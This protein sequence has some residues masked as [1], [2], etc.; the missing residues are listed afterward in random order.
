MKQEKTLAERRVRYIKL[1]DHAVVVLRKVEEAHGHI[2]VM[3]VIQHWF[4]KPLRGNF[5]WYLKDKGET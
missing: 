3:A 4:K 2:G 5:D 1:R